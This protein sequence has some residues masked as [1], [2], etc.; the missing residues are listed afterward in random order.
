MR[1]KLAIPY[2]VD[3]NYDLSINCTYNADF[4][5]IK[6]LNLVIGMSYYLL[7]L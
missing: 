6:T 4:K 2:Y 3:M 1:L 5:R 7:Y